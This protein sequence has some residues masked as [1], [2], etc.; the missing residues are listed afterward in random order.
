M[1]D[2]VC[3]EQLDITFLPTSAFTVIVTSDR[4]QM[5]RYWGHWL[6]S[7]MAFM[8]KSMFWTVL[9]LIFLFSSLEGK[10]SHDAVGGARQF[11]YNMIANTSKCY[12]CTITITQSFSSTMRLNLWTFCIYLYVP[13]R[14]A[15]SPSS[16][17]STHLCL[18]ISKV[19]N[20][21]M[22][23]EG[24]CLRSGNH[25][26]GEI[27]PWREGHLVFCQRWCKRRLLQL[28]GSSQL[29]THTWNTRHSAC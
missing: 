16:V 18:E 15:C 27:H 21:T 11:C 12:F 9:L 20:L 19:A 7:A 3:R 5:D 1:Q 26:S 24:S 14:V 8:L 4:T 10:C 17:W 13:G 6:N 29:A 28:L 22:L 23:Q 2:Q 25:C